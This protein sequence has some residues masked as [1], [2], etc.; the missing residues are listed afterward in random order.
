MRRGPHAPR[1]RG[2]AGRVSGRACAPG[3][4]GPDG[5]L[6][7]LGEDLVALLDALEVARARVAGFSL[8]GTVAMR[9]AIDHPERVAALALVATSSR[10]GRTAADWYRERA[11]M[12]ENGDSW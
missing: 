9:V 6:H 3:L 1:A 2:G 8:G 5:T 7:Q 12:V 11:S 4:G 10:V